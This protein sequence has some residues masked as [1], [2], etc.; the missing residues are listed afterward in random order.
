MGA[1]TLAAFRAA[2]ESAGVVPTERFDPTRGLVRFRCKGDSPGKRNGWAILHLD[3]AM[4]A[5]TPTPTI[6]LAVQ[7]H[8]RWRSVRAELSGVGPTT[9]LASSCR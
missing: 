5:T 3:G 1:D 2:M 6:T 7:H 9:S 8:G 4:A